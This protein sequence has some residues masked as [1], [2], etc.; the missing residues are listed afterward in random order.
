MN[1]LFLPSKSDTAINLISHYK[2]LLLKN[3]EHL[4]KPVSVSIHYPFN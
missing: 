4:Q 2:K 3:T 1:T